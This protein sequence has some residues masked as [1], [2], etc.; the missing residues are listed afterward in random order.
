[1]A[2]GKC[3]HGSWYKGKWD[4]EV[5]VFVLPQ[6]RNVLRLG[7][8]PD[9]LCCVFNVGKLLL[10]FREGT[11]IVLVALTKPVGFTLKTLKTL[12]TEEWCEILV[13]LKSATQ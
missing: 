2:L 6:T 12:F 10:S 4:N 7:H 1:M 9:L 3:K 8:G 13:A 11:L 5:N